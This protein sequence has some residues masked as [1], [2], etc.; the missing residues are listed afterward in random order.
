MH[1]PG[2][3]CRVFTRGP[4]ATFPRLFVVR[5]ATWAITSILRPNVNRDRSSKETQLRFGCCCCTSQ[6][7]I[8]LWLWLGFPKLEPLEDDRLVWDLGELAR[9]SRFAN[10]LM[11]RPILQQHI[12][13]DESVTVSEYEKKEDT[14]RTFT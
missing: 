4:Y 5:R 6:R 8:W 2:M 7:R 13:A 12:D 14:R 10:R 3:L 11:P 1:G 9:P